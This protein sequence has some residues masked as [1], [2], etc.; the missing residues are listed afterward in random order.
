M[1]M[2]RKRRKCTH[3]PSFDD[4]LNTPPPSGAA[5][6]KRRNAMY[7]VQ[8]RFKADKYVQP[9]WVTTSFH[10]NKEAA[11]EELEWRRKNYAKYNEQRI[12]R[13]R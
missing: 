6:N 11:E 13:V 10:R 1:D 5:P 8:S 12:V 7:A 4:G 2:Q 9:N 3:N